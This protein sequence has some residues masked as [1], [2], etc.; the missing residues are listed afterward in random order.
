MELLGAG[1]GAAVPKKRRSGFEKRDAFSAAGVNMKGR[2]SL[3][4]A[5]K[6][7]MKLAVGWRD[8]VSS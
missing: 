4:I 5:Y 6:L 2:E 3:H 1:A 7:F 8:G